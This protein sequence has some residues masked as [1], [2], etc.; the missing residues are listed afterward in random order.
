MC[1]KKFNMIFICLCQGIGQILGIKKKE[2]TNMSKNS[3][4]CKIVRIKSNINIELFYVLSIVQGPVDILTNL[5]IQWSHGI[6]ITFPLQMR[7]QTDL[8]KATQLVNGRARIKVHVDKL[9][10]WSIWGK[11]LALRK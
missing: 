7:K 3:L 5:I 11:K 1:G 10:A 9:Q 8:S 2:M 4:G 6:L